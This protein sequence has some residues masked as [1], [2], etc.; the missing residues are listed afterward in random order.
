[1]PV[2]VLYGIDI[3]VWSNDLID[4]DISKAM[5]DDAL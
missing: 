3:D 5:I 1:M 4:R 2:G